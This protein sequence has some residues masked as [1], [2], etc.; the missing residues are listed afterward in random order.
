MLLLT[1]SGKLKLSSRLCVSY[2]MCPCQVLIVLL[3]LLHVSLLPSRPS[4]YPRCFHSHIVRSNRRSSSVYNLGLYTLYPS[5]LLQSLSFASMD[6][7]E[8]L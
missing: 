2:W 7:Q 1:T 6:T 5:Q 3:L 4:L 8:L